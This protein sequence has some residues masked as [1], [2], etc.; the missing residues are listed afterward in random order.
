VLVVVRGVALALTVTLGF[1]T[2]GKTSLGSTTTTEPK[3]VTV[4][5]YTQ[6]APP[7]TTVPVTVPPLVDAQTMALWERVAQCESH[8]NWSQVHQGWRSY[9]GALGIRN[10]VWVRF[11]G[12]QFGATA[13]NASPEEQVFIARRIQA[14]GGIPNYVP[15]QDGRC[16][17][18]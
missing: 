3:T 14:H 12:L 9:S 8:K 10:D 6:S 18:W 13:G 5:D 4:I 11:G 16:R 7:T 17:S 15:D 1:I 2:S